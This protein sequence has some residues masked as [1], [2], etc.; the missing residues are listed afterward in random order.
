MRLRFWKQ[1]ADTLGRLSPE[2][3]QQEADRPFSL[4]LV[5]TAE[6][7]QYWTSKLVPAELNERKR[8]QA[9]ARLFT[10][11]APIP[12]VY[13]AMLPRFDLRLVSAASAEQVLPFTRDYLLLPAEPDGDRRWAETLVEEV[14]E[15]RPDL[16]LPLA[17]HYWPLRNP[18]VDRIIA[19]I[20]RE[21]AAF[22]I[23]SAL[24]NFIPSPIQLPWAVGEFASD[25]ALIT[26]NQFRMAFLVAAAS[27][28]PVG[29]RQ[30]KGQ[31]A[32][33]A[34]SAF[35]WRALAR[36]LAGKIP[37]GGGLVAKGLIAYSATYA[38][39]RALEH[40]HRIGRH[41]TRAEKRQA[42]QEA[43]RSGRKAVE[44]LARKLA[45]RIRTGATK[46]S[47]ANPPGG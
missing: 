34:G 23:L 36:E 6:E 26:A 42:Y 1:L 41:F 20:A 2:S 29:W 32:S 16:P 43:L 21:N 30:Q 47:W 24:P 27:D 19:A 14:R 15:G 13:A 3:I 4:A 31:L 44:E 39:G 12:P 18:V 28:S 11:L 35:G 7:L 5:G 38:V 40:F 9:L 22:A 17:R 25:T 45:G 8:D 37:A 10:F 46:K 33:I